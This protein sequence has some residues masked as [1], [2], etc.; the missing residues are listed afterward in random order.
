MLI[1]VTYTQESKRWYV[2]ERGGRPLSTGSL[3]ARQRISTVKES[4]KSTT[5][6]SRNET[7]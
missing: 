4:W 7:R 2:V 5:L 3:D 1:T 6:R